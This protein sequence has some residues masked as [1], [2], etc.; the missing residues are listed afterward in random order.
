MDS[1][2]Q[3]T[4]DLRSAVDTEDNPPENYVT[5]RRSK[6]SLDITAA[7]KVKKKRA[8]DVGL[9]IVL[10]KNKPSPEGNISAHVSKDK[11]KLFMF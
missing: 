5:T 8:M 3:L 11:G 7:K 2:D 1:D 10:K 4:I 9:K 6:S